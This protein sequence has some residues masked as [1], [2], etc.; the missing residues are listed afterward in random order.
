MIYN[1]FV[2]KSILGGDFMSLFESIRDSLYNLDMSIHK[3]SLKDTLV[4]DFIHELRSHFINQSEL[5]R[6]NP[7]PKDTIL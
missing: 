6:I 4:D 2:I 7:L 3:T 5:E 1:V